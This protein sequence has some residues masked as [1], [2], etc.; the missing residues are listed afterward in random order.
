MLF[1]LTVDG[2]I[3]RR[4]KLMED[5]PPKNDSHWIGGFPQE[6]GLR[7]ENS[8]EGTNSKYVCFWFVQSARCGHAL[9]RNYGAAFLMTKNKNVSSDFSSIR[10]ISWKDDSMVMH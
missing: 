9:S 3:L 2:G 8:K 10:S 4:G 6:R 5:F 1:Q 7:I